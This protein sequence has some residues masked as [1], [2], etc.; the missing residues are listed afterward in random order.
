[1]FARIRLAKFGLIQG[2][3]SCLCGRGEMDSF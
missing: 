3:V 2:R 1:M